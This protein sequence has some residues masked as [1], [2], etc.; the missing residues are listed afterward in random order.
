MKMTSPAWMKIEPVPGSKGL[1]WNVGVQLR[2]PPQVISFA[3]DMARD[4]SAA[5]WERPIFFVVLLVGG[6]RR[7][8]ARSA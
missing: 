7:L 3:W 2:T 4:V 5:W 6:L 8:I 1:T